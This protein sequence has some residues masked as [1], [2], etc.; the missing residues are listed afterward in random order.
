MPNEPTKF[1]QYTVAP[2]SN[3]WRPEI[4]HLIHDIVIKLLPVKSSAPATTTS[5]KPSEK[6]ILPSILMGPKGVP[7][8]PV[9]VVV[10]YMPPNAPANCSA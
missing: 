7:P 6:A 5:I 3:N 1:P 2:F 4:C 9:I 10:Q 8:S